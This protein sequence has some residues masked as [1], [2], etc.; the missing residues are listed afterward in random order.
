M[1]EEGFLRKLMMVWEINA[2]IKTIVSR[3]KGLS[4]FG[5][6]SFT[7]Y[8]LQEISVVAVLGVF[9]QSICSV[10]K[11]KFRFFRIFELV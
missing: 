9:N 6:R 3:L 11:S 2:E 10:R 4:V 1:R 8:T 7:C 5:I